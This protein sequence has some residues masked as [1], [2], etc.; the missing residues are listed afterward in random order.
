MNDSVHH[1]SDESAVQTADLLASFFRV[2]PLG[3]IDVW[4]LPH[5]FQSVCA[6]TK[7]FSGALGVRYK[8]LSTTVGATLNLSGMPGIGNLTALR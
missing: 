5:I 7:F 3:Q 6:N 4:R 2:V 8:Y 1:K